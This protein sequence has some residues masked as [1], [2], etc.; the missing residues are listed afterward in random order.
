MLTAVRAGGRAATTGGRVAAA[1]IIRIK[2][3]KEGI[4]AVDAAADADQERKV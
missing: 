1:D 3:I 2:E 4:S